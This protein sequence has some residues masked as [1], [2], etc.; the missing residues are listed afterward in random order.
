MIHHI[1]SYTFSNAVLFIAPW[2][3]LQGQKMGKG[4]DQEVG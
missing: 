1:D 2:K 4:L 3:N